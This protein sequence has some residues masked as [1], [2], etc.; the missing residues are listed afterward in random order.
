MALYLALSISKLYHLIWWI[1]QIIGKK[2]H[3]FIYSFPGFIYSFQWLIYSFQWFIYSFWVWEFPNR[4]CQIKRPT[5]TLSYVSYVASH[6][7]D[8]VLSQVWQCIQELLYSNQ[9]QNKKSRSPSSWWFQP[10]WKKCSSRWIEHEK[11]L[12]CHHV[13]EHPKRSQF[14]HCRLNLSSRTSSFLS[15]RTFCCNRNVLSSMELTIY[16]IS[17]MGKRKII[18]KSY[19][20][21]R[22]CYPS[23][24]LT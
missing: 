11:Y 24:K 14:Q 10:I 17:H 18:L 16:H 21:N 9:P 20:G 8:L 5:H 19:L 4:E 2:K 3:K 1:L 15:T 12:S 13:F 6:L 7:F 22:I 23:L